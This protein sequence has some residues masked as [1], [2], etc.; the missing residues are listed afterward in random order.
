MEVRIIDINV[1]V[2]RW[3]CKCMSMRNST[4]VS[5]WPATNCFPV[6]LS[7]RAASQTIRC[8]LNPQSRPVVLYCRYTEGHSYS[9]WKKEKPGKVIF[10]N[11]ASMLKASVMRT[12]GSTTINSFWT[13]T[14]T[15]FHLKDL[16][17][18]MV[19]ISGTFQKCHILRLLS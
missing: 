9:F 13:F 2:Y 6:L 3:E 15:Q 1:Y 11:K 5:K 4:H 14:L 16:G 18:P 7:A 8:L 12:C 10:L 19:W 17:Q